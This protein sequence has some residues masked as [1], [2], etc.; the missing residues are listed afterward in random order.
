MAMLALGF[1]VLKNKKWSCQEKYLVEWLLS[2]FSSQSIQ[3]S[4]RLS[5]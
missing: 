3:T 2:L 4:F 1:T 5:V